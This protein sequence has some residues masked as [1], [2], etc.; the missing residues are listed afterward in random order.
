M[1]SASKPGLSEAE[2]QAIYNAWRSCEKGILIEA[3]SR[4]L[5]HLM[6]IYP[7]VSIYWLALR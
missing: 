7:L 1:T 3:K 5:K 4:N 2:I 6:K